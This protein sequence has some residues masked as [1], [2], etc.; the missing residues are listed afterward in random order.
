MPTYTKLTPEQYK[1]AN[2]AFKE[3]LDDVG[4]MSEFARI[5]G[6]SNVAVH[7][8]RMRGYMSPIAAY[9]FA[10]KRRGWKLSQLRPDIGPKEWSDVIAMQVQRI[11]NVG[12]A[13]G[14]K[15]DVSDLL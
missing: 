1:I 10:R 15:I 9:R 8:M 5:V 3:V 11:K 14:R 12:A 7:H 4:S 6:L 13:N 2:K